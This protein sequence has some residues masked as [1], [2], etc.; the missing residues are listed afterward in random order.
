MQVEDAP[1]IKSPV[2]DQTLDL[3]GDYVFTATH[4]DGVDNYLWGF[5]QNGQLV[6]ETKGPEEL[7]ISAADDAHKRFHA[8]QLTVFLRVDKGD[9]FS[10]A[11]IRT[12]KLVPRHTDSAQ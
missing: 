5:F 4:S 12:V 11:D 8:D 2:H 1:E 7:D 6:Y 10:D 3:E 9:R